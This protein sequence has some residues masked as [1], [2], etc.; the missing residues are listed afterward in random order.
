VISIPLEIRPFSA[1]DIV[2]TE[3]FYNA[4]LTANNKYMHLIS[5][6]DLLLILCIDML[7]TEFIISIFISITQ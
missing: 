3:Q 1:V 7:S 5:F 2:M 4:N 6:L